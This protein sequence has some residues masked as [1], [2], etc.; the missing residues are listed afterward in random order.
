M[1]PVVALPD[2]MVADAGGSR[3]SLARSEDDAV[4]GVEEHLLEHARQIAT[5]DQGRRGGQRRSVDPGADQ[6]GR[7]GRRIWFRRSAAEAGRA[8]RTQ[9]A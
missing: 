3:A 8:R 4:G 6:P 7:V 5:P 9:A 2:A 1:V